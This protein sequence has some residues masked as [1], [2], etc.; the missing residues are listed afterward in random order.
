MIFRTIFIIFLI[1]LTSCKRDEEA[2][3]YIFTG[4]VIDQVT[5]NPIE[6]ASVLLAYRSL[7]DAEELKP[8]GPDC[9]SGLD[10]KFR[11]IV[12]VETYERYIIGA[13]PYIYALKEGYIGS[14]WEAIPKVSGAD[15]LIVELYHYGSLSLHVKHDSINDNVEAVEIFVGVNS[16]WHPPDYKVICSGK[17]Y[18]EVFTYNNLWGNKGYRIEIGKIGRSYSSAYPAPYFSASIEILPDTITYYSVSFGVDPDLPVQVGTVFNSELTYGSMSDIDGNSYKTIKIGTQTWMAENLKTVKYRNGDKIETTSSLSLDIRNEIAPKYQWAYGG[19]EKNAS[20]YGRLYTF[21]AATDSRSVCPAGWHVPDYEEW[22]IMR[23]Y[24]ANNGYG[25]EGSGTDIGK[26][27]AAQSGWNPSTVPGSVGYKQSENNTSG[28]SA[29][30]GGIRSNNGSFMYLGKYAI[31]WCS[32][33]YYLTNNPIYLSL[34]NSSRQP[35]TDT[36]G[37]GG[38]GHF[39]RCVKD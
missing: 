33:P 29:L 6:K 34:L 28:F 24:L 38:E 8:F 17:N 3:N 23:D 14:S 32:K 2:E 7:C 9:V 37:S 1:V 21:Y 4:V 12:P 30:P 5:K 16:F 26:S 15:S 11:I 19:D 10:G 31:W 36:Q 25:Y 13:C 27:L 39:V 22:M 20:T 35:T 18:D